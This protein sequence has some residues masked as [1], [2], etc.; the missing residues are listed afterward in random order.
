MA[1]K[2]TTKTKPEGGAGEDLSKLPD[3]ERCFTHRQKGAH[4][5]YLRRQNVDATHRPPLV[6][7]RHILARLQNGVMFD[8]FRECGPTGANKTFRDITSDEAFAELSKLAQNPES[9]VVFWGMRPMTEEEKEVDRK[10]KAAN[11]RADDQSAANAQ[12][13]EYIL[14]NKL[15]LPE[16]L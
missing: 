4:A 11:K 9:P 13:R 16:G 1:Q 15:P 8:P 14:A 10:I 5:V 7:Q 6:I 2:P 3:D 12:L